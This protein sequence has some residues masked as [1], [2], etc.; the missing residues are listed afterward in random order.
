MRETRVQSL[1][2]ED[3]LEKE[4]ATHSSILAWK[5]PWTEEPVRLQSMRLQRVGH[6]WATSLS[7]FPTQVVF[8][9][10]LHISDAYVL[11]FLNIMFGNIW[12]YFSF[13]EAVT[14]F[15]F[16]SWP[17]FVSCS[18]SENLVF[19]ACACYSGWLHPS[20]SASLLPN[21][22]RAAQVKWMVGSGSTELWMLLQLM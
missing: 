12:S 10:L 11:G 22:C 19:G 20:G 6:E 16:R 7:F 2:W 5:I 8:F 21:S 15:R 18:F 1:G 17:I 3:L 14:L 4:M 13:E 9:M